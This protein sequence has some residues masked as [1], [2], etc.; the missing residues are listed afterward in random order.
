MEIEEVAAHTP[1]KIIKEA[2][3]PAV[4][5]QGHNGRNVAFA[6][7]LAEHRAGGHQSLREDAG[8]SLPSVHGKEC[9]A[10]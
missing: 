1:E 9:G 10:G 8:K 7:G 4:G 5:F 3:D 2:I 6:L